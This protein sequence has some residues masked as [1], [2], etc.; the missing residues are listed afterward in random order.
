MTDFNYNVDAGAI[1]QAAQL[2]RNQPWDSS[3]EGFLF[4]AVVADVL[5]GLQAGTVPGGHVV[6]WDLL[7]TIDEQGKLRL[8]VSGEW[9]IK[10]IYRAI[11]SLSGDF[12]WHDSPQGQEFWVVIHNALRS[13]LP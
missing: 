2:L 3:R 1:S 12:C 4:W 10:V 8:S 7:S 11:E 13:L 5:T 6:R 9:E